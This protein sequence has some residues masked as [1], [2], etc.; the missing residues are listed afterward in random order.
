MGA[1]IVASPQDVEYSAV[2][3]NLAWEIKKK[4]ATCKAAPKK[5][6]LK[7]KPLDPSEQQGSPIEDIR[8]E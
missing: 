3:R 8:N 4:R 1:E 7:D 6:N 5:K 2:L